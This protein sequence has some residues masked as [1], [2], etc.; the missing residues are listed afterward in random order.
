M[1]TDRDIVDVF[2]EVFGTEQ[3]LVCLCGG[4]AEPAYLPASCLP[5]SCSPGGDRRAAEVR[6]TLDYP[7]SALHEA[8]HWLLAG[9]RRRNLPDYG[10]WYVSEPRPAAVQR[11]FLRVE[12][13]VQALESWLCE[14]A[15]LEFRASV[16]DFR[17]PEAAIAAFERRVLSRAARLTRDDAWPPAAK[18][19]YAGLVAYRAHQGLGVRHAAS[20]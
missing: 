13:R 5:A 3:D 4:F 9:Q 1:L 20:A 6:Y 10:Y 12:S 11:A 2:A 18:R 17:M 8:A 7:A 16:D 19:F 15:G 14:A